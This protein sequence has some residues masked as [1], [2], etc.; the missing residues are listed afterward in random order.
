MEKGFRPYQ[1]DISDRANEILQKRKLVVLTA[2]VRTGKTLMSLRTADIYGAKKVL[3]VTKKKA[4]S[5]IQSDYSDFG[6]TFEMLVINKE[7]IHKAGFDFDFVVYDEVHTIG[8]AFPKPSK[9]FKYAKQHY[10]HLPM[11]LMSGTLTPE[12]YSQI[13]HSLNLSKYSPFAKYTNFYKWA[14]DF[15]TVKL[16]YVSYGTCN[17]YSEANKAK[18]DMFTKPYIISFT[19]AEAGFETKVN[20]HILECEMHPQTYSLIAR[21]KRD[22]VVQGKTEVIL[23]DTG[24]KLMQKIHQLSSGTVKFE[25]GNSMITDYSK[26]VFIKEHFVGKKIGIFYK[27][28]E[29]LNML[30]ETFKDALTTDLDTFNNSSRNIA[31]QI[32]SGREGINLSKADFLVYLNIDFSAT[33]YWQSRDRLTTM[34]RKSNDVYWIFG[35]GGIEKKIYKSVMQKKDYTLSQFRKDARE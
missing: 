16:K 6:F 5:S 27:F 31:L 12:S 4:I 7:S 18:I 32:V 28:K 35:V 34:E 8:G 24:V 13:Y 2:E 10:S 21:L 30:Q 23:A 33:S 1:I 22:L 3:F 20:E 17:D 26:A 9:V 29:E 25:S 14:K 15:V 11:I 19:Q